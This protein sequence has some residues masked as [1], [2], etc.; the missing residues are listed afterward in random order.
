MSEAG[1][2]FVGVFVIL[3][4]QARGSSSWSPENSIEVAMGGDWPRPWEGLGSLCFLCLLEMVTLE[5]WTLRTGD[6]KSMHRGIGFLPRVL[7][8]TARKYI[9]GQELP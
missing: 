9:H 1:H 7:R 8:V 6:T 2:V 4:P 3:C 5:I